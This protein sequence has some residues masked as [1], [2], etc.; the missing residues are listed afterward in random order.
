[1]RAADGVL[2]GLTSGWDEGYPQVATAFSLAP[3]STPGGSWTLAT[4]YQFTNSII[5]APNSLSLIDGV[6]YG[7]SWK[8]GTSPVCKEFYGCGTAFSLTP[9]AAS[10]QPWTANIL[11]SFP[12]GNHASAPLG[13]IAGPKGSFYGLACQIDVC[14]AGCGEVFRL[15]PKPSPG[16]PWTHTQLY[17][18]TNRNGDGQGWGGVAL[19]KEGVIYGV[20]GAG[21]YKERGTVFSLAPPSSPGAAWTETILHQFGE[22]RGDGIYPNPYLVIGKGGVLYGTTSSG[23]DMEGCEPPVGCGVVFAVAPPASPGGA[24]TEIVLYRFE[25]QSGGVPNAGLTPG[26]YGRHENGI[27][28]ATRGSA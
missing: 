11:Y 8:G 20:T 27:R 3:P 18:F 4:I 10:G 13:I 16:G 24:W 1:V 2:Y 22:G 5:Q 26:P 14:V 19:G 25:Y 23:G 21:G 28:L 9:P 12:G 7:T 15:T 17:A 6:I